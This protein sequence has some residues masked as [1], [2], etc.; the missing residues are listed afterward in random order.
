M[1][2]NQF[3]LTGLLLIFSLLFT[4]FLQGQNELTF[5]HLPPI[6]NKK[7]IEGYRIIQDKTGFIWV[8]LGRGSGGGVYRYDGIEYKVVPEFEEVIAYCFLVDKAD[9]FWVGSDKGLH[10]YQPRL[11]T[12]KLIPIINQ[13]DVSF[14][15]R[16]LKGTPASI[17][18][19]SEDE[20]GHFWLATGSGIFRWHKV[21]QAIEQYYFEVEIESPAPLFMNNMYRYIHVDKSGMVWANS[22]RLNLVKLDPNT[23]EFTRV[24]YPIREQPA[25]YHYGITNDMYEDEQG[26]LWVGSLA[27]LSKINLTT[28]T[29]EH[30]PLIGK[31]VNKILP[32]KDGQLWLG[33]HEGLVVLNPKT[34]TYEQYKN[35]PAKLTS[36]D[37]A[38]VSDLMEDQRGD[39]WLTTYGGNG[40][41][42]LDQTSP[43]FSFIKHEKFPRNI[44]SGSPFPTN[45]IYELLEDNAGDI[46]IGS[47][48]ATDPSGFEYHTLNKYNPATE[49]VEFYDNLSD[50]YVHAIIEDHQN[51]IW[52]GTR[53]P[54]GGLNLLDRA[55]N[56]LSLIH[57]SEPTRPY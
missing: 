14:P 8:S 39:I 23:A 24:L 35:D 45:R 42:F 21:T 52:V 44:P 56:S 1:N 28:L 2:N 43:K 5:K 37:D 47:E 22:Q 11:G 32:R 53:G 13:L 41:H 29:T 6:P 51:N 7:N 46:W 9:N 27:G 15:N 57:I 25:T 16:K 10:L 4:I 33:T 18:A 50:N 26:F 40:V 38:W 31:R 48:K 17:R 36:L 12:F 54:K 30:F 55:T 19:I 20:L 34:M 3:T 49:T